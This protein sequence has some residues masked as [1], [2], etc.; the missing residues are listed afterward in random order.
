L[1]DLTS[2]AKILESNKQ[3]DGEK[4]IILTCSF[5]P[6]SC[7]LTAY[8]LTPSGYE[9]GRSNKDNGSN[10]HGY[11]P[12]HYE[13]VQMLLSDRFLGFYMVC[14]G[15]NTLHSF[16]FCIFSHIAPTL[17]CFCSNNQVPDNAPWNFNFMGVK[18]DPQMKYNMKLGMPRDFYH[19]DHRPTHFLEFSNIEEGEVAEGDR[20]DTFS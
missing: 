18:H 16:Y 17:A 14:F 19:E 15:F 2:H 11:L 20:E 5:T 12:T 8:K 7:S 1:Q 4:C 9:W 13:K 10:P 3:W 6:G